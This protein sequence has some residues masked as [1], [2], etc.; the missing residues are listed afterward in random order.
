MA[1]YIFSMNNLDS[2]QDCFENGL[3]G[4]LLNEPK[5]ELW[6][7][8]NEG[9][10][11]DYASMKEGDHVFF[12]N[13]RKIY[14]IGKLKNIYASDDR[15]IVDCKFLNFPKADE[16]KEMTIHSNQFLA[17]K[18]TRQRFICS[19]EP[20]PGFFVDGVDMDDALSSNSN[21]FRMLRAFW[22]LSFVKLDDDEAECLF[23]IVLK[24]CYF[25][26]LGFISN[27]KNKHMEI[28]KKLSK[29]YLLNSKNILKFASDG[30]KSKHEMAVEA[31]IIDQLT[32]A[33]SHSINI[34]GKWHYI[35]HQVI[36]S[37]F[38]AI[39]YMDKIDIFAYSY[40][41]GYRTKNKY[42]VMELKKDK[43]TQDDIEQLLK[44]VDWIKDEYAGQD[45]SSI[46]AFLV[47][48]EFE[49]NVKAYVNKYAKR[50]YTIGRRPILSDTWN[51]I[52]LIKYRYDKTTNKLNF[53]II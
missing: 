19:F 44:Y 47:A 32:K 12:F 24:K 22:K 17:M 16:P 33:D 9:T 29:D 40:I 27:Y 10:F 38:K 50:N 11:A 18:S 35:S 20:A 2:I 52:K 53:T 26:S 7:M 14:G 45:Y 23:D 30:D 37:P 3:Y 6:S 51:N 25:K 49:P 48:Y 21:C 34:F 4:T 28:S 46:N 5:K 15:S 42:A 31:A 13:K 1:G 43:A 36:A 41:E 39:D 8:P